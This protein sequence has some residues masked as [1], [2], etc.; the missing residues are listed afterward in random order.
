MYCIDQQKWHSRDRQI[1]LS[2]HI[3]DRKRR[4]ADVCLSSSVS[5]ARILSMIM[6][7]PIKNMNI[8]LSPLTRQVQVNQVIHRAI[9]VLDQKRVRYLLD[10]AIDHGICIRLISI[11]YLEK[12]SFDLSGLPG[13]LGKKELRV[14][15]GEPITINLPINGSPTPTVTWTKDGESVQPTREFVDEIFP[16]SLDVCSFFVVALNSN[17][18]MSMPNCI[19][20][21]QNVPIQENIKFN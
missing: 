14:K 16:R 2:C 5:R 21:Q 4:C 7:R 20:H 15:A 19:S 12:P 13:G 18:M 9:F 1:L 10:F 11:V 17:R 6:S 3:A 8:V